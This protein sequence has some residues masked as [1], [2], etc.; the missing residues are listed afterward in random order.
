MTVGG[1][2]WYLLVVHLPNPRDASRE[3]LLRWLVQRNLAE[4]PLETQVALVDRLRVEIE[5]DI[6]VCQQANSLSDEQREQLNT[7]VQLLKQVWFKMCTTRYYETAAENRTS[8]LEQQIATIMRWAKVSSQFSSTETTSR[9]VVS[10]LF[11]QIEGWIA[12]APVDTQARMQAVVKDGFVCWLSNCDLA[13]D[14]MDTRRAL[15][16]RIAASVESGTRLDAPV[17]TMSTDRRTWL[18]ANFELLLEAWVYERADA[19]H[20][21]PPSKQVAFV[22]REIDRFTD[23]GILELLAD[24]HTRNDIEQA[25][26]TGVTRLLELVDVWIARAAPSDQVRLRALINDVKAQIV[27]RLVHGT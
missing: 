16:R 6:D 4:E 27:E 9:S 26:I 25:R 18:Q 21:T 3:Q 17:G 10:N 2:G 19:F 8:Y 7:N 13:M 24:P 1:V 15:A 22:D 11:D 20:Q 12:E 23:W 14:S 5:G